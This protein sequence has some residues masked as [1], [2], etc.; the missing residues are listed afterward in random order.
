MN[1]QDLIAALSSL[2]KSYETRSNSGLLY[3]AQTPSLGQRAIVDEMEKMLAEH[4][5]VELKQLGYTR[6]KDSEV[7]Q[8]LVF[9][10]RLAFGK[11]SGRPKSR[12]FIDFLNVQFPDKGGA[13]APSGSMGSII[14]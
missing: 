1:D 3:E 13:L 2:A 6:L 5:D 9:L 8:G 12:G 7:L 10:I 14:T 11:T 4:R